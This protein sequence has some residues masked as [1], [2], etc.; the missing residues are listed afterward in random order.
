MVFT[1]E[2]P[3]IFFFP[4]PE[5]AFLT[6]PISEPMCRGQIE[7]ANKVFRIPSEE[8]KMVQETL[9]H[10]MDLSVLNSY[11]LFKQIQQRQRIQLFQFKLEVFED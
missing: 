8:C 1:L 9:F 11:I 4:M 2:Y 6:H 10:V 3:K 7:Y 5:F